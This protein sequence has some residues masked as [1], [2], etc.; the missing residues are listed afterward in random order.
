MPTSP[1]DSDSDGE[2]PPVWLWWLGV[3]VVLLVLVLVSYGYLRGSFRQ[4]S[5]CTISNVPSL[6]D[7]CFALSLEGLANSADTTG[8]LVG[9]W[10]EIDDVYAARNTAMAGADHLIQYETY[11]MTPGRRTD[12]FA[13]VVA[14][15]AMAGVTVQLLL[16]HQGTKAM[17]EKYWQRLRNVGVEIQ[18]FRPLDWRAP[19]EYNSRSHRKLLIVDGRRVFIGGAGVSDFWDGVAFE[20]DRAPW[21]DFEV[22]YEGEVV[23]LLQGKFLQNWSCAGGCIDLKQGLHSV[24]KHGSTP[25]Y[26]TDN[27]SSLNESSMRLLMQLHILA[28]KKRLWIGS[29]Y[30]VPDDDTTQALICACQKGVDVRILTMGA[31]TDKTMVHLASRGLYGPLLKAGIKICEYQ[32]SMM[33]AKFVLVD[34]GWVSTGSANFDPR[35]YFHNDELNISGAYPELARQVEQFFIDAMANSY[36]ISYLDWQNRPTP[37]KIK[38]QMALLFRQLL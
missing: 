22:A 37:E 9:F 6:D 19:L 28:A 35:S 34:D 36:C 27:T 5:T 20:H 31:A 18:F 11:F 33:H 23:S 16:D 38:G 21:L 29:P 7:P 17:P 8:H 12:A 14:D 13:E 1:E 26:I 24:Q 32:P 2:P 15:R 25:L 10:R 30:L 4:A 3:G